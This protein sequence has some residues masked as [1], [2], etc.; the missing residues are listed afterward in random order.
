[1][2][3][4]KDIPNLKG[5]TA[6]LRADFNVP[7]KNE[8]VGDTFR[9]EKTVPTIKALQK[10][11]A[12][13]VIISHAGKDG[14]QSLLPMAKVLRKY[15]PEIIFVPKTVLSREEVGSF[16][17]KSVILLENLRTEPGEESNDIGFS[18][19]LAAMGDIYVNDA[20]S[21]SHRKH[22]SVVGVAKFLP[23]YAGLQLMD[24]IKHLS[25]AI[26]PAHP[27]LFILGGAKFDTKLPLIQKYLKVADTVFIGG[28]LANNFFKDKGLSVGKSLV[29]ADAPSLLPLLKHKKLILPQTVLVANSDG[30][31]GTIPVAD[32]LADDTIVD[33]GIDSVAALKDVIKKAKLVLW[34]GPLGKGEYTKGTKALLKLLAETKAKTIIGGGDTVEVISK[35]KMEK[36]FTF[37]STGGGATLEFLAS[38]SLPGIKVLK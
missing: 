1:M 28:A 6:L 14:S 19:A 17:A 38:G 13:V 5:K 34:N 27:F 24:E 26:A 29:D 31:S 36:K 11:G 37:V 32:V 22:A 30:T 9:I 18:Q 7:I 21:V 20:F 8:K 2:K 16:P 4:I 3:I 15:I 23:G 33:I 12:R 25:L 10:K 35:L